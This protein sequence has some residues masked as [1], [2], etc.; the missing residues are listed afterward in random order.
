MPP[1]IEAPCSRF[2]STGQWFGRHSASMWGARARTGTVPGGTPRQQRS[3]APRLAIS[4]AVSSHSNSPAAFWQP[5]A[6]AQ[7]AGGHAGWAFHTGCFRQ[8]TAA[9]GSGVGG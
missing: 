7:A 3:I 1:N 6:Q 5:R 4:A 8:A 9:V 2:P